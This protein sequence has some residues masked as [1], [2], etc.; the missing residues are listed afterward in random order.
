M[1]SPP[2]ELIF[3]LMSNWHAETARRDSGSMK[4][5]AIMTLVFLPGTF[6][7]VFFAVPSLGRDHKLSQAG[8]GRTGSA[9]Y[10]SLSWYS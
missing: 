7:A 2:T 9:R 5:I 8:R 10:H 4:T 6:V 1:D 3:A